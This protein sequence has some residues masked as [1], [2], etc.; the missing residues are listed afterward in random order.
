MAHGVD[1]TKTPARPS[2]EAIEPSGEESE[3]SRM[4]KIAMESA[5]RGENRQ[6]DDVTPGSETFS[7]M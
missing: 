6:R 1:A 5:K 7:N 3:E 4:D 2:H